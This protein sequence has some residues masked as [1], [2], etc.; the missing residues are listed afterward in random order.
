VT[1][2]IFYSSRNVLPQS[3]DKARQ[4]QPKQADRAAA[5]SLITTVDTA[6]LDVEVTIISQ[7]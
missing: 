7:D 6:S 5:A 2:H 1:S 3:H 4:S